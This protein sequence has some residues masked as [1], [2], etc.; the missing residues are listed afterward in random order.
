[1]KK[2]RIILVLFLAMSLLTGMCTN[3]FADEEIN[4]ASQLEALVET[5][6]A[7]IEETGVNM[8]SEIPSEQLQESGVDDVTS[9]TQFA[10]E[11]SQADINDNTSE[12]G[13]VEADEK[14]ESETSEEA[15]PKSSEGE[16][17]VQSG[18]AVSDG[19]EIAAF[20]ASA[21]A[22]EP[23]PTYKVSISWSGMNFTYHHA[24]DATWDPDTLQYS[25]GSKSYWTSGTGDTRYGTITITAES[26]TDEDTLTATLEF[27][28]SDSFSV[29]QGQIGMRFSTDPR[30]VA[31]A[32]VKNI[33]QA[34]DSTNSTVAVYAVPAEI[35]LEP[36]EGNVQLGTVTLT[37][38]S[39]DPWQDPAA[40]ELPEALN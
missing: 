6:S 32:K 16:D 3:A 24:P 11:N 38:T 19:N 5:T 22:V 20:T 12:N 18:E 39:G 7:V 31:T 21:A 27:K 10:E 15:L 34:L 4:S 30:K 8:A 17:V 28:Q 14:Q 9:D 35:N 40:P 29:N 1:M 37:I 26:L 2:N 33:E 36:F 23:S 25:S 13:A